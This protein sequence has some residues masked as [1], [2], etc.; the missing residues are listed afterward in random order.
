M[1]GMLR[2]EKERK[3]GVIVWSD[4]AEEALDDL[5]RAL[6]EYP[7][8]RPFDPSLETRVCTDASGVGIGAT[9]EQRATNGEPW[10]AVEYY[11]A[12][13]SET[14]QKWM[15]RDQ[16]LY[17]I[18][19]ALQKWRHF[20]LGQSFEVMTD[21]ASLQYL[22]SSPDLSKRAFRWTMKLADYDATIRYMEGKKMVVADFLSRQPYDWDKEEEEL[23]LMQHLECKDEEMIKWIEKSYQNDRY[24]DLMALVKKC[25][26]GEAASSEELRKARSSEYEVVRSRVNEDGLLEIENRIAVG[27]GG[28]GNK[29]GKAR[30]ELLRRHHDPHGHRGGRASALLLARSYTWP[31][32]GRDME[33][34]AKTCDI[35]AQTTT[36]RQRPAGK[37]MALPVPYRVGEWMHVDFLGPLMPWLGHARRSRRSE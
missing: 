27:N 34:W 23:L 7:V 26:Q 32:L 18:V 17:A 29:V 11:S 13:L 19:K 5:K 8:L 15:V 20:L 35:C 12:K 30:C 9:L 33:Q 36:Q 21:H 10:H 28:A 24:G 3:G 1:T 2:K 6:M 31:G 4:K 14:E 16:E 37:T 25:E 22:L